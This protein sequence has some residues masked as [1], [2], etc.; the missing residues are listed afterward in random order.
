[1]RR[2]RDSTGDSC[3]HRVNA[4]VCPGI[5]IVAE[6]VLTEPVRRN[7][8]SPVTVG[9]LESPRLLPVAH[10]AGDVASQKCT[11]LDCLGLQLPAAVAN[12]MKFQGHHGIELGDSHL[13]TPGRQDPERR[14]D[15]NAQPS[16]YQSD[17]RVQ[18]I[19]SL[20]SFASYPRRC[21]LFVDQMPAGR[22]ARTTGAGR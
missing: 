10:P 2:H 7:R 6:G 22:A 4:S 5:A 8:S 20:T 19:D 9:L 3:G 14:N 17:L 12:L 15:G 18:Q 1:M 21:E 16:L 11:K 13:A